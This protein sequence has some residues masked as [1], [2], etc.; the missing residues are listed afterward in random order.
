MGCSRDKCRIYSIFRRGSQPEES[1]CCLFGRESSLTSAS[2][3]SCCTQETVGV[4]GVCTR[5]HEARSLPNTVG[6]SVG[7]RAPP[8]EVEGRSSNTSLIVLPGSSNVSPPAEQRLG[9]A[10]QPC[11]HSQSNS[12]LPHAELTGCSSQG[13]RT[14]AEGAA[15]L[16]LK[17]Q[18]LRQEGH[19]SGT[20][21]GNCTTTNRQNQQS[22]IHTPVTVPDRAVGVYTRLCCS[23]PVRLTS[24]IQPCIG[25]VRERY[26]VTLF[27][28]SN[29]HL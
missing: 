22:S 5:C 19:T 17:V 25:S 23:D 9:L 7:N 18:R 11:V 21:H 27:S 26:S 12:R 10:Q 28:S 14:K 29:T 24:P 2:C 13:A 3:R 16:H 20:A 6:V 8:S 15:W 4:A 1:A